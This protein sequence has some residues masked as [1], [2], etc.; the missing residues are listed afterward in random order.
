MRRIFLIFMMV[1]MCVGAWAQT[2]KGKA[3]FYGNRFNGRRTAS[4]ET[5]HNDSMVCAHRTHP[6]GTLLKVTNKRNGKSVVVR[7]IDRGPYAKGRIIDLSYA[8]AKNIGMISSGVVDC[9]IEV[10]GKGSIN[11]APKT[12]SSNSKRSS[13]SKQSS[14]SKDSEEKS[15][16]TDKDNNTKKT[17][18]SNT[19][20]KSNGSRT[21]NRASN[22]TKKKHSPIRKSSK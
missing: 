22:T 12:S 5:L 3:T 19:P 16:G 9:E 10:V 15:T 13:S 1:I 8:A 17:E 18:A 4:G 21:K 11:K 20:N 14:A 6:F 2:E 7:V